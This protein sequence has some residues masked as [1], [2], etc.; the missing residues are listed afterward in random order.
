MQLS[1][2][3]AYLTSTAFADPFTAKENDPVVGALVAYCTYNRSL[4]VS[5]SLAETPL[6]GALPL[7]AADGH[8]SHLGALARYGEWKLLSLG[9]DRKYADPVSPID[10]FN[11]IPAC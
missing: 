2:P 3:V 5:E 10:F 11:P 4:P 1:T 8:G 7:E 6:G 9:P